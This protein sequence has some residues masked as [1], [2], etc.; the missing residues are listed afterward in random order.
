M[1]LSRQFTNAEFNYSNIEKE[2]LAIASTATR[3]K[4][5]LTSDYRPLEFIFNPRKTLPK[6]TTSRI[7]R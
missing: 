2:A 1:Y 3:N 4:I 7:L 6:V 5:I